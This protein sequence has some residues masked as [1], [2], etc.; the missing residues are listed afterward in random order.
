MCQWNPLKL[1]P[2]PATTRQKRVDLISPTSKNPISLTDT[3]DNVV[4][5]VLSTRENITNTCITF[6]TCSGFGFFIW[7]FHRRKV[8][9]DRWDLHLYFLNC[10][11]RISTSCKYRSY[12]PFTLTQYYWFP[13]LAELT[14]QFIISFHRYLLPCLVL[15]SFFDPCLVLLR[16]L[17]RFLFRKRS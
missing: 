7:S 13:C 9:K 12:I 15:R 2:S 14:F 11:T 1:V 5:E 17:F 8:D 10:N 3:C 16:C 6:P 4:P